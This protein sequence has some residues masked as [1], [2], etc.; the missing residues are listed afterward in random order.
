MV[1]GIIA[2]V[3]LLVSLTPRHY[4]PERISRGKTFRLVVGFSAGGD[5]DVYSRAISRHIAKHIPG[6]PA[7]VV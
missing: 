2:W 4:R 7:V 5:F 3:G 1:D 6:D